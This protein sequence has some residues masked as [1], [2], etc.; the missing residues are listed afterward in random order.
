M[1]VCRANVGVAGVGGRLYAVGG[2]SGKSFLD[3]IEYLDPDTMEWTNFTPKPEG[4]KSKKV[5]NGHHLRPSSFDEPQSEDSSTTSSV[6]HPLEESS[7]VFPEDSP[8]DP[9]APVDPVG[10]PLDPVETLDSSEDS[11]TTSS[12]EHPLEE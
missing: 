10:P 11:S 3:T 6:A 5:F 4:Y 1:T 8:V 12:A 7:S 9:A 2:F